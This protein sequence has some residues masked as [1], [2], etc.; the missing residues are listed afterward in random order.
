MINNK[1]KDR[2]DEG[3]LNNNLCLRN[4]FKDPDDEL[5]RYTASPKITLLQQSVTA[6]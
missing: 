6:I 5:L 2:K 4:D 1:K 3:Q